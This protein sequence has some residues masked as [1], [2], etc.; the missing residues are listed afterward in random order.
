MSGN[1]EVPTMTLLECRTLHMLTQQALA[2]ILNVSTSTI[3]HW[4]SGRSRPSMYHRKLLA[5]LFQLSQKEILQMFPLRPRRP[6][7]LT[8]MAS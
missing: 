1:T 7:Q 8:L 4:E 3:A 2:D 5:D 6:R